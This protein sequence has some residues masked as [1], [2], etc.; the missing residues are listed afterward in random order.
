MKSYTAK[1]GN[2]GFTLIELLVVIAI[3]GVL[4]GMLLPT[5][6]KAKVR[7]QV[8]KAQT[9][10]SGI[11]AAIAQYEATYG[12]APSSRAARQNKIPGGN[13]DQ[14]YGTIGTSTHQTFPVVQQD[15]GYEANNAEIMAILLNVKDFQGGERNHAE[16]PQHTTFLNAKRVGDVKGGGIGPD[17]VYRDPWGNPYIITIDL[18]GDDYCRDAFYRYPAVSA[19]TE[20]GKP[21]KGL[22]GMNLSP[23]GAFELSGSVMVWSFGPDKAINVQQKAGVGA[24]KDNILSWK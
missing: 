1:T 13:P 17:G 4:A 18:N 23:D 5:L 20:P 16:N 6:S 19:S 15:G 11:A 9:E 12:R 2:R 14:T 10:I 3:I 7:A 24:N 22:F 8:M 21:K